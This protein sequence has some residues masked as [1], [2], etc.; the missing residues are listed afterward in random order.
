MDAVSAAAAA[1]VSDDFVDTVATNLRVIGMLDKNS[2]LCIRRGQLAIDRSDRMQGIRRWMTK[3]SRDVTLMHVRNTIASAVKISRVLLS[4]AL[5][6]SAAAAVHHQSSSMSG[7]HASNQNSK[8]AKTG[9]GGGPSGA[10]TSGS[11]GSEGTASASASASAMTSASA[12]PLPI[13]SMQDWTLLNLTTEMRNCEAGLQN[14]RMTYIYD[15]STVASI[16]VL[17]ERLRA[18]CADLAARLAR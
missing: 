4:Q 11:E 9:G 14:L 12:M 7:S 10:H 17:I 15:S 18:N 3:D 6:N 13:R 8:G 5:A 2:K 1:A 16:D